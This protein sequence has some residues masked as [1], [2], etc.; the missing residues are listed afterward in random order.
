VDHLLRTGVKP[1]A[2]R[3]EEQDQIITDIPDSDQ[4]STETDTPGS[5]NSEDDTAPVENESA[6]ASKT[7]STTIHCSSCIRQSTRRLV[8]EI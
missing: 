7:T 2:I 5:S 8:E 1:S 4:P 3:T 6:T